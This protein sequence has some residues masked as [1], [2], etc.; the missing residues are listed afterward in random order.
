M[1]D[2]A[3]DVVGVAGLLLVVAG[4]ASWSVPAAMVVLGAAG[5]L[6][7]LGA[8]GASRRSVR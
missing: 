7:W 1:R 5:I 4:V 3:I 6:L 8:L 2:V